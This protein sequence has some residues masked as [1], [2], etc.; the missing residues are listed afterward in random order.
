MHET[1]GQQDPSKDPGLKSAESLG[2]QQES[3]PLLMQLES[4]GNQADEQKL[5]S[6]SEQSGQLSCLKCQQ[7]MTSLNNP[8]G[9]CA[10]LN[11]SNLSYYIQ[12]QIH[13]SK[14]PEVN[15]TEEEECLA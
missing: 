8:L 1:G 7:P 15:Q 2:M 13:L 4:S 12:K 10:L 5:D 6:I 11:L 3:S 14:S 9:F